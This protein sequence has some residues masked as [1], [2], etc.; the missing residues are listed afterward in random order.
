M[1]LVGL[2]LIPMTSGARLVLGAPQ[3]FTARPSRW[4]QWI[5]DYRG[6]VTAGPNFSWALVARGLTASQGSPRPVVPAHRPQRG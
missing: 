5:H 4:M 2:L 1:G 6:T 3:D